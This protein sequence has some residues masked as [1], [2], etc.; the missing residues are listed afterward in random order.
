MTRPARVIF[1]SRAVRA[2]LQ[3]VKAQ[4][5][6]R[7]IMAI[8]K[9]DAYGHGVVRMARALADADAFGVASI[10]E[11]VRL[12]EADIQQ[13]IV[14]LEGPFEAQ[15]LPEISVH[16]LESVVHTHEQ[17]RMFA[18]H[19][20][21][22]PLWVKIDT[23]MHRLGFAPAE[24]PAVLAALARPRR[25]IRLMTHFASAHLLG[26]DGVVAQ[27]RAFE[28]AAEAAACERC[29]ANSS[30]ILAWPAT[31]ADW[32]R[33]GLMLY[34]V[35]PFAHSSAE[36]LG[37]R[38]VMTVASALIAVK[39][40]AAGGSV[41]YGKGFVCPQD[42]DIGVVAFG[43]ADGYPRHAATGTPILVN[44]VRTQVIGEASMDMMAVDLRPVRDARVGDP[45][46]LWGDGLPV[47]EVAAAAGTIPYELLCR[48]RMRAHFVERGTRHR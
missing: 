41:G 5:P 4:A 30:A 47:E 45:V 27:W 32:V 38:P 39:R 13:R 2:N 1:D 29:S 46:V 6:G 34:G 35:S 15:E 33:P 28:R 24:L 42:M 11:A 36:A 9:A 26:D 3:V 44:G 19:A 20:D 12:R 14:L 40:V 8:V 16:R 7:R 22:T 31:H 25:V 17:V 21:P 10:E 43:Y 18:A 48:M 37:L 23:G